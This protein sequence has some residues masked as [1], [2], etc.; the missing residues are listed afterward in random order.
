LGTAA[1]SEWIRV[2]SPE[3]IPLQ[4]GR[5]L[6]PPVLDKYVVAAVPVDVAE[7]QPV[8]KSLILLLAW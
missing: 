5:L 4:R 7:S 1:R 3:W 6:I 2:K 8:E